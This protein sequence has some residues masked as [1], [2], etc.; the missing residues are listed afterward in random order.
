MDGE[1]LQTLAYF[2]LDLSDDEV[3]RGTRGDTMGERSVITRFFPSDSL[4]EHSC[5]LALRGEVAGAGA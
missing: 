1:N 4:G 5:E 3:E 2:G